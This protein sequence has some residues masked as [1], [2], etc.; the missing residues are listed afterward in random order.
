MTEP[1]PKETT[2]VVSKQGLI[3]AAIVVLILG[4]FLCWA[5]SHP[6][7]PRG[8]PPPQPSESFM[9]KQHEADARRDEI[10]RSMLEAKARERTQHK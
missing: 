9:Q 10:E 5:W 4:G 2:Q 3:G 7:R 1:D 6:G 8:G